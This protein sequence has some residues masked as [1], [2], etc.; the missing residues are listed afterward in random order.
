[1]TANSTPVG[2]PR[3][4]D[5]DKALQKALEVFWAKVMKVLRCRI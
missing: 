2:R 3:A 5:V 1:M 4:F